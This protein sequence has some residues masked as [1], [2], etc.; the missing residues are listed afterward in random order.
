M[1]LIVYAS[2]QEDDEGTNQDVVAFTVS[3]GV[4]GRG[5][6]QDDLTSLRREGQKEL[7]YKLQMRAYREFKYN[8]TYLPTQNSEAI[9]TVNNTLL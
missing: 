4:F 7:W 8:I 2:V 5:H 6:C 9:N 3:R 1:F